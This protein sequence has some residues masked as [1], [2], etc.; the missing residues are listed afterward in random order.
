MTGP[1][2]NK[3]GNMTLEHSRER[4]FLITPAAKGRCLR[5]GLVAGCFRWLQHPNRSKPS[6]RVSESRVAAQFGR[7]ST[8]AARRA[9]WQ[10]ATPYD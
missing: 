8:R 1:W 4:N 6:L 7:D 2:S 5:T 3:T 10:I 9:E